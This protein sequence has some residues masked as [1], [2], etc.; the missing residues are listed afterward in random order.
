MARLKDAEPPNLTWQHM[1]GGSLF[2]GVSHT[3]RAARSK[4]SPILGFLS[5]MRRA[6]ILCRRTTKSEVVTHVRKE[7]LG[8]SY[9]FHP[10]RA[11]FQRALI[12]GVL[13]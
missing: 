9:A 4:R 5:F 6:Y 11:E 10:E 7:R 1:W 12:L 8:V 2:L 3:S 13:L